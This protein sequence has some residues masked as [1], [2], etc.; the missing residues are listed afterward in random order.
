MTG[1]GIFAIDPGGKTGLCYGWFNDEAD[2]VA[3]ALRR[4]R[5]KGS[6]RGEELSGEPHHQAYVIAE[7][8]WE[9]KYKSNV[10][11]GMQLDDI[12]IVCER[13]DARQRNFD[14]ASYL[15]IG[16]LLTML[17]EPRDGRGIVTVFDKKTDDKIIKT[18]CGPAGEVADMPSFQH[19][20]N[21]KSF[22]DKQRMLRAD[23]WF[24][25]SEHVRD[26]AKHLA[27]KLS[28]VLE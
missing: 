28:E 13:F 15:V 14:P 17:A 10:E 16:G 3:S 24:I 27:L 12:H 2:S 7:R 19:A 26:A 18:V 22:F 23:A 8:W 5:R 4:A 6:I 20:A 25:G 9:F 1:I 11:Y 21:A